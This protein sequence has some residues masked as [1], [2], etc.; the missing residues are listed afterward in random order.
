VRDS[1]HPSHPE[2]PFYK[3]I[4]EEN[5]RDEGFINEN[6]SRCI[7]EYCKPSTRILQ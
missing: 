1:K 4:S 6:Y 3:G 7:E 5:V 2:N